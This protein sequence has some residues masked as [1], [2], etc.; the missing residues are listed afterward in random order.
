M[1]RILQFH[2][3]TVASITR[4]GSVA[5]LNFSGAFLWD[6][7]GMEDAAEMT[8]WTQEGRLG[9]VDVSGLT[10]AD[11]GEGWL[12]NGT[13]LVDFDEYLGRIEIPFDQTGR[14]AAWFAF[15]NGAAVH[16]ESKAVRLIL[17][18]EPKYLGT[19]AKSNNHVAE[20]QLLGYHA[21]Q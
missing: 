6:W 21:C 8:A 16:I 4:S 17:S 10:E 14:I 20:R 13:V 1:T 9:F 11:L 19:E 3:S 2:D 5:S 12:M 7:E 15:N 18:G